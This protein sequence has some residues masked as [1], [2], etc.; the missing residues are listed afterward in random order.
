MKLRPTL[1]LTVL[2]AV[3]LSGFLCASANAQGPADVSATSPDTPAALPD[4]PPAPLPPSAADT[5]NSWHGAVSIYGW[6]AGMHGT[7]GARGHNT[8]VHMPFSDLFHYLKGIIPIAVEADKGR[9]VFP[10]DFLWI[11]LGDDKDFPFT[12]PVQRSVDLH[13]TQSIL[14]PKF[15]YRILD[16][17]RLKIDAL[18]GIRYWHVGQELKLQPSGYNRSQ[19][20]NWVDGLGG[21]RFILPISEKA[22]I[23]VAGDAGGGGASLD[24]QVIG[25]LTYKFT[26]KLGLGLGWRYLDVN[27]SGNH[28]FIY[29][30]VT[31]GALGGMFFTFGGKPPVPPAAGCTASPTEIWSGEPVTATMNTQNFN[32]K[33]TLSYQ[34]NSSGGKV[35]GTNTSGN[36]DTTGLAPGTYTVT[37]TAT[38]PKEKKNNTATCNASF[39]VKQPQPP[40]V[41]C[42]ASP[43]SVQVNGPSTISMSATDPQGWPLTYSWS[44]TAGNI[45][46]SG[47][48]ANLDSSGA[49]GG[50]TITVTG[51]AT[52]SRG[53]SG[54]C[55]AMVSVLAPPPPVTVNEVSV[56]GECKFK[57]RK[58]PWRVDNEC[59]AVLDD[60]A[61]RLQREP[62]G[63]LVVVGYAVEEEKI[64]YTQLDGQRAVNV[65]YYLTSGEG[66]Q[67]IDPASIEPRTGAISDTSAK[68]YFVPGGVT[69]TEQSIVV[70]ETK[71]KGQSRN[72][73]AHKAKSVKQ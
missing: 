44:S 70:D 56:V 45:S 26:P 27:Y 54:T 11:K 23:V 68:F 10:E 12:D 29:D 47:T 53:L 24:Y 43:S 16:G 72:A 37:G 59:K 32:P 50:S 21:M 67:K 39:T 52:D 30:T 38:D 48:S 46:G 14:T 34:W 57:D 41:S 58:R 73:P 5:N 2:T 71:V 61:L 3:L 7:V 19:A 63:K 28:Q 31:T 1:F 62:N 60:V 40:T 69:F 49:A 35:S 8:S 42:S 33:H 25:L 20:A 66:G 22:A 6:F 51:T 17:E 18:A 65:K 13:V 9:W 4:A 64:K 36:V 55:N 15:G